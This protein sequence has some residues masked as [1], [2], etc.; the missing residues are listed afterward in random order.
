MDLAVVEE[1]APEPANVPVG[2]DPDAELRKRRGL[3]PGAVLYQAEVPNSARIYDRLLGG[4]DNFQA[5]RDAADR[6]VELIP[7]LPAHAREN[8]YF[9]HRVVREL[10]K[11]GIDQF[12][13]IGSGLPTQD[14]THEVLH[15]LMRSQVHGTD[16]SVEQT[17]VVYVDYDELACVHGRALVHGVDGVEMV[18]GD[19]RTPEKILDDPAVRK[20]IDFSR[21]VAVL[22]IAV[23]HFVTDAENPG[24]IVARVRDRLLEGSY[25]AISHACADEMKPDDREAAV[26]VYKQASAPILPRSHAEITA[27]FDGWE[28]LEPGVCEVSRWRPELDR[29]AIGGNGAPASKR[30][31]ATFVGG[32]AVKR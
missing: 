10:A 6:L 23:L 16:R 24:A 32:V 22:M 4:K 17:R 15:G 8:R 21:P 31:G 30:S 14:N 11:L 25:L 13:D 3:V 19:L 5:D 18:H 27:L 20:L 9:L 1:P 26:A 2:I 28:L 12:I 7:D 29:V